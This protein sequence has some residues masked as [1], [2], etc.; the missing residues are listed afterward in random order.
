MGSR[1][2]SIDWSANLRCFWTKHASTQILCFF[3]T[4]H[5]ADVVND[6]V[7]AKTTGQ[8]ACHSG[9]A[10]ITLLYY[11][12]TSQHTIAY[13]RVYRSTHTD[14]SV[15]LHH[16]CTI[17]TAYSGWVSCEAAEWRLTP[18]PDH[19]QCDDLSCELYGPYPSIFHEIPGKE[20]DTK[21]MSIRLFAIQIIRVTNFQ[22]QTSSFQVSSGASYTY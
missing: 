8:S 13:H 14:C 2:Q 6:R 16:W 19:S 1:K 15:N 17:R 3:I 4:N 9:L 12:V 5:R 11:T 21:G 20:E 7:E 22:K 10:R 18:S